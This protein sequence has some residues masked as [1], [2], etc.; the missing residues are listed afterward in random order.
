MEQ[1]RTGTAV[2]QKQ[3]QSSPSISHF[4]HIFAGRHSPLLI[5]PKFHDILRP[6]TRPSGWL[7]M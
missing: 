3:A 7:L 6:S 4:N 2:A 1:K 5:E